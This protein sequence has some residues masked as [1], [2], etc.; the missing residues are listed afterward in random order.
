MLRPF[1]YV[2]PIAIVISSVS[3]QV[4]AETNFPQLIPGDG[5]KNLCNLAPADRCISHVWN[6][7]DDDG[8]GRLS[9]E[10]I[11]TFIS[12]VRRW[13]AFTDR[14]LVDRTVVRLALATYR[15]AGTE[16]LVAA[17]DDDGDGML[18]KDEA[19]ADLQMDERTIAELLL[20]GNAFDAEALAERFGLLAPQLVRM[21]QTMGTRFGGRSEATTAI[22]AGPAEDGDQIGA[23]Q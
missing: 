22:A 20:D 4:S 14:P 18:S 7:I 23:G 6:R 2:L 1:S 3:G 13:N 11:D 21:A 5:T 9:M 17:Y 8:D 16:R 15:L 12:H 19:L 10:E